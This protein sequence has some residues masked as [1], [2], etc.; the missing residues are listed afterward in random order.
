VAPNRR[1]NQT[2]IIALS[3]AS[4]ITDAFIPPNGGFATVI[5]Q[6][7]RNGGLFPFDNGCDDFSQLR[8]TNP[9]RPFVDDR[10]YNLVVPASMTFPSVL[11]CE[12]LGPNTVDPNS[13]IDAGVV[14]CGGNGCG[15]V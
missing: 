1:A 8:N 4:P 3:S 10:F 14:S 13:G 5:V 2:H 12:F 9:A 11:R 7:R 15:G 6:Y